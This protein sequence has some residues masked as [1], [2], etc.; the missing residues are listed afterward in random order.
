MVL[1]AELAV[2]GYAVGPGKPL[3]IAW[4]TIALCTLGRASYVL[5]MTAHRHGFKEQQSVW[6]WVPEGDGMESGAWSVLRQLA[7]SFGKCGRGL[8]GAG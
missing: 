4:R 1:G 8:G 2:L 3:G 5:A 6:D 7:I